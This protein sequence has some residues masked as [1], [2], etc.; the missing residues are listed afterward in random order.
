MNDNEMENVRLIRARGDA[1]EHYVDEFNDGLR[2]QLKTFIKAQKEKDL[3]VYYVKQ[4]RKVIILDE[5]PAEDLTDKGEPRNF[6]FQVAFAGVPEKVQV[7]KKADAI[8]SSVIFSC[9][10]FSADWI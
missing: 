5:L 8:M 4:I 10:H 2:R 1:V 9:P 6:A 7:L 3:K